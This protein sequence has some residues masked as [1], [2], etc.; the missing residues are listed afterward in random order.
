MPDGIKDALLIYNPA[1]GRHRSRRFQEIE[2]AARILKDAGITTEIASTA[3]RATAHLIARQAVEQ[4][5]G[6]VVVCGGDGTIN[7]VVNGL[8]GS[9]VPMAL[10]PAGTA[11]ILAKELGI[12]WD[13]PHAARLIPGGI[14]RRIALGIAIPP[15][16]RESAELPRD[17]RYFFSVA[18]AGPDGAIV[19]AVHPGLKKRTGEFAYWTAGF[20]QLF[21]YKFPEMLI[22]SNGN[23]TRATII[24][25]GRTAH[26]G[27][28][29]KI[30]IGASLFDDCFEMLTHSTRSRMKYLA[31]L[32]AL[33]FG[34]LPG[35]KGIA[36]W[37]SPEVICEPCGSE[38]IHAHVDGEP[39]GTL[40][41]AFRVV[42]GAISIVTPAARKT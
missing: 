19:N 31:S 28:P 7:E 5:R 24:V 32:P 9:N 12:P 11:N 29:F 41:I 10:L 22:R 15:I 13:I 4:R 17:G 38:P 16:G 33:C 37:K 18:G 8:A 36:V 2:R 20:R 6:M 3:A 23:E 34:K 35:V 25:I 14:V 27:G 1:S 26:Y 40:P 21:E 39:I 30:T 42:P